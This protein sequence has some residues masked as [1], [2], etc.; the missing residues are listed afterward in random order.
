MTTTVHEAN[1]A[2]VACLSEGWRT[3][4]DQYWILG[5]AGLTK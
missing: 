2:P 1:L 3:I 4:K 5:G